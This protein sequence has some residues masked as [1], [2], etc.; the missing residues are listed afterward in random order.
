MPENFESRSSQ[1][2]PSHYGE[3]AFQF[4][5]KKR[6]TDRNYDQYL[7]H[8]S[9]PEEELEGKRILDI[10]AGLSDFTEK[11]NKKF[12]DKGT[13]AVALDLMYKS[14]EEDFGE[15]QKRVQ[16]SGMELHSIGNRRGDIGVPYE[17]IKKASNKVAGSHQELPF[18]DKSFDLIFAHNSITQHADRQ[19]TKKALEEAARV[20]A[21][22]GEIRVQPADLR[23]DSNTNTLYVSTFDSPTP[24]SKKE[25]YEM[26]LRVAADKEMFAVLKQL[27]ESGL[28]FYAVSRQPTGYRPPRS[29]ALIGP[30]FSF[31]IRKDSQIPN[32]TGKA[33]LRKLS[34]NDSEDG[35]H[36]PSVKIPV[37]NKD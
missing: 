25:A 22:N 32:M 16:E 19:V 31:V 24:D 6:V 4:L 17:K 20:L 10:G 18:A 13:V 27:E 15:F 3:P 21:E 29:R 28:I 35:F 26:G 9:L 33:I 14:L 36:V 11:S 5:E 8:F 34:F 23:W 30:S 1:E 37:D 12:G 7:E 2:P